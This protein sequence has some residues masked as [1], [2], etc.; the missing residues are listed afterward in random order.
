MLRGE[1]GGCGGEG[2]DIGE[3]F[4]RQSLDGLLQ[5]QKPCH[6][7][8]AEDVS[9][10]G[11]IDGVDLGAAN[12]ADGISCFQQAALR[13]QG[14]HGQGHAAFRQQSVGTLLRLYVF[15]FVKDYYRLFYLSII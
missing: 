2:A 14:H 3:A 15:S 10:T 6:G 5:L 13:P 1:A 4:C 9:G 7:A 8:A 12:S 11:G